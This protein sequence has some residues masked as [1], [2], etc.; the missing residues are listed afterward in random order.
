MQRAEKN[1]EDILEDLNGKFHRIRQE[2][3]DEELFDLISGYEA[4]S[5]HVSRTSVS[6]RE[7]GVD[8]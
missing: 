4:L 2:S 8:Q 6:P 7:T 5:K 1:I 3:I